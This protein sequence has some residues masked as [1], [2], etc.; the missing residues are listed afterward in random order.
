MY[1]SFKTFLRLPSNNHT[2]SPS[3]L[4]GMGSRSSTQTA[5]FGLYHQQDLWASQRDVLLFQGSRNASTFFI[6]LPSFLGFSLGY[7]CSVVLYK[8]QR[9]SC[10]KSP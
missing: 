6:L 5:C 8:V 7:H 3:R 10:L 9:D 2:H 4:K 1:C